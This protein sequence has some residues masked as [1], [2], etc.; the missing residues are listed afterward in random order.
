ENI[1]E[2]EAHLNRLQHSARL[3]PFQLPAS[4]KQIR[5]WTQ[6]VLKIYSKKFPV[7][8]KIA[9]TKKDIFIKINSLTFDSAIYQGVSATCVDVERHQPQAK[10]YPY[11]ISYFAHEKAEKAGFYEA[12]LVDSKGYVRE[13]A[14][15]N[16]FW[17]KNGQ[18]FTE[19]EGALLGIT[20]AAVCSWEKV[21]KG[22]V[23][24]KE[25]IEMDEVFLT[26]TTTGAVPIIKI[27]K[28][29]IGNGKPGLITQQILNRF[30]ALGR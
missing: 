26:K 22:H 21:K 10:A 24:P 28:K 7:R 6:E 11:T 19:K 1:F 13:G 3:I 29:I 14:Y 16:L 4:L 5:L 8:I 20:Q 27:D 2:L 30:K 18:I 9:A 15:S 23:T 12:L 25:L 17:I